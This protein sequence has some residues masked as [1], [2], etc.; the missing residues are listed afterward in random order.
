LIMPKLLYIRRLKL[1]FG[2][3]TSFPNQ[4]KA[5]PN[6]NQ[7][8]CYA[9]TVDHPFCFCTR[10]MQELQVGSRTMKACLINKEYHA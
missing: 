2:I 7:T 9:N 10:S 6:D 5:V 3:V 8:P 4:A 1:R